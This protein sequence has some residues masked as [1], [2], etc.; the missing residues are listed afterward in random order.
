MISK[1]IVAQQVTQFTQVLQSK[2]I[3]NPAASGESEENMMVFGYRNQWSGFDNNPTTYYLSYNRGFVKSVKQVHEPLALRTARVD[4]Y[5]FEQK[6]E[7][8]GKIKHGIGANI[9]GDNYGAFKNMSINLSYAAHTK[10]TKDI[11]LS[12]GANSKIERSTLDVGLVQV[13]TG[14]DIV[15]RDFIVSR[16]GLTTLQF[17]LG[18]YLYN[19]TWFVGYSTNQLTGDR[20]KFGNATNNILRA[21]HSIIGGYKIDVNENIEVTPSAIIKGVNG[22]PLNVTLIS[23][24]VFNEKFE[25]GAGYRGQDAILIL[26]GL[27]LDEKYRIGYSYDLNTSKLNKYNSGSHEISFNVKF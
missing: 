22:T 17:D 10:I 12:F 27:N 1:S 4:E 8:V 19:D 3:L 16:N 15:Y 21:H 26:A 6:E 13:E 2:Y 24:I 18:T 9:M 20:I 7:S 25:L 14:N 11:T 5:S 23:N